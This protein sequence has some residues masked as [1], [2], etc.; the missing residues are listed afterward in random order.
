MGLS[1]LD[2]EIAREFYAIIKDLNE[3]EL[4]EV[5]KRKEEKRQ[6]RL[7][8]A[9]TICDF[10]MDMA[11]F[12]LEPKKNVMLAITD[13][14]IDRKAL[15]RRS[16]Q[17]SIDYGSK[18]VKNKRRSKS[19]NELAVRTV[20]KRPPKSIP[21]FDERNQNRK[22]PPPLMFHQTNKDE[23]DFNAPRRG[24]KAI[25]YKPENPEPSKSILSNIKNE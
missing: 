12:S 4:E 20:A 24:P 22:K 10:T 7:Q 15:R 16:S 6:K 14:N 21:D 1:F 23:I 19:H 11:H 2:E 5:K 18:H 9:Q 13:G 8:L 17:S 25:K 3:F